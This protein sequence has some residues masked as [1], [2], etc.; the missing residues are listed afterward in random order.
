M[1]KNYSST[2]IITTK[3]TIAIN[4]IRSEHLD[5]LYVGCVC[6]VYV[7]LGEFVLFVL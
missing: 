1:N 5:V 3:S 7:Y 4:G 6:I 2:N